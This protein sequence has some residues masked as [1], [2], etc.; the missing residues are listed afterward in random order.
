MGLSSRNKDNTI[1]TT[2]EWIIEYTYTSATT[3][4]LSPNYGATFFY[5]F[6]A[7]TKAG[8]VSLMG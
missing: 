2:V 1:G 7:G 6:A 8:S 5:D 4:F 3:H